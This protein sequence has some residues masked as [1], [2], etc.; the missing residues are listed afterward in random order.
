MKKLIV[1]LAVGAFLLSMAGISS[2]TDVNIYGAS[3]QYNFWSNLAVSWM[4]LP[5]ASGGAGCGVP[6]SNGGF[7]PSD[8]TPAGVYYHG[9]KYFIA[10]AAGCDGSVVSDNTLTIRIGSYDSMDGINGVLGTTNANDINACTGR[11]RA[12]LTST[13]SNSVFGCYDVHLG[14]S[15]VNGTTL[16]QTSYGQLDGPSGPTS[17]TQGWT[18]PGNGFG[19]VELAADLGKWTASSAVGAIYP[20]EAQATCSTGALIDNHPFVDP[21]AFFANVKASSSDAAGATTLQNV[22]SNITQG[23]AEQIF[24]G[25]VTNWQTYFPALV[26]SS[27]ITVCLRVA[28][29]GTYATFHAGVMMTNENGLPLPTKDKTIPPPI[30]PTAYF[31]NTTGDMMNCINTIPGAIGFA[32]ASQTNSANTYQLTFN[33][34]AP[35]AANLQNGLYDRF[36]SLE[37]VFEPVFPL[38]GGSPAYKDAEDAGY[39][40]NYPGTAVTQMMSWVNNLSATG[41]PAGLPATYTNYWAI[42]PLMKVYKSNDFSYPPLK[43][44]YS[45]AAGSCYE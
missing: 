45:T 17:V 19:G 38:P 15:D 25:K 30:S 1:A 12:L 28:G 5:V 20:V 16:I 31:N 3:A 4:Q 14:A 37:H 18:L 43:G 21:F 29:S 36:W 6:V 8:K 26:N 11:Q 10:T 33:G 27:P 34:V 42:S 40:N 32:D 24:S 22:M 13:A 9:A 41:W 23:M 44:S 2:A 39:P 7:T 35:T